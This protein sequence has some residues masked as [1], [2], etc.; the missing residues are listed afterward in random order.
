MGTCM[1]IQIEIMI[2]LAENKGIRMI[3]NA[4]TTVSQSL[5]IQLARDDV[6]TLV[7]FPT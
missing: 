3:R 5:Y 2:D 6:Q 7:L 4:H 1:T